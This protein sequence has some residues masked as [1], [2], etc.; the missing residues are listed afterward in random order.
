MSE[1]S[2]EH[3]ISKIIGSPPG[4]VGFKD[5]DV[6]VDKIK[7]RPYCILLLDEIEKANPKIMRLFL[8]VMQDGA[9]T[10][11]IGEKIDCK[12]IFFIMTG[13]FGMNDSKTSSIGFS[14]KGKSALDNERARLIDFCGKAYGK[15]FVNR[16]DAFVP[17]IELSDDNLT[18]IAEIR[19]SEFAERINHKNIKITISE[20]VAPIIVGSRD[21]N[22]G[23]N[24][25]AIN[26]I[27]SKRVQPL[28]AD[29]ILD[30]EDIDSYN[31]T[32][33]IDVDKS[34]ELTIRKRK[35]KRA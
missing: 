29:A 17:F 12:N 1:Y 4:Y 18:R 8:Q 11:A 25:M 16:V 23:M 31:Y 13:N 10:S 15:E 34:G 9:I 22:H 19:L 32:L 26:R 7:R 14:E 28:V 35:R 27:I 5:V 3:S 21:D 33:T 20:K 2:E 6:V 24:A 30:I